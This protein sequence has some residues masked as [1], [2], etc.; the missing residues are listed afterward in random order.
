V[1]E[2]LATPT[3]TPAYAGS[4]STP[5]L[6]PGQPQELVWEA[7]IDRSW[8]A[9]S[10]FCSS[11]PQLDFVGPLG[12]VHRGGHISARLGPEHRYRTIG[13]AARGDAT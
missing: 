3:V 1:L 13:V 2:A 12:H 4:P 7:G 5:C 8:I 11:R 9:T 6:R 10:Q